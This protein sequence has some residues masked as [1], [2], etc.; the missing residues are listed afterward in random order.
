MVDNGEVRGGSRLSLSHSGLGNRPAGSA[1]FAL[2]STRCLE[3]LV[4][5]MLNG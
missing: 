2:L 1:V 3:S 5:V 4:V